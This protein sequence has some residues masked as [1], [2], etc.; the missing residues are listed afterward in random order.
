M[1][2]LLLSVALNRQTVS[3]V[4]CVS[5]L[6]FVSCLPGHSPTHLQECIYVHPVP[7]SLSLDASCPVGDESGLLL[8]HLTRIWH[9]TL[10]G[11]NESMFAVDMLPSI[12]VPPSSIDLLDVAAKALLK[13]V[14]LAPDVADGSSPPQL[15]SVLVLCRKSNVILSLDLVVHLIRVPLPPPSHGNVRES[16]TA[17]IS[18]D[19]AS[20]I[21]MNSIVSTTVVFCLFTCRYNSV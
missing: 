10:L 7:P 17:T 14:P 1:Q 2:S 15:P 12:L 21:T 4:W 3:T 8:Q 16:S 18:V 6:A 20:I 11:A 9:E 13:S 19:A 5:A